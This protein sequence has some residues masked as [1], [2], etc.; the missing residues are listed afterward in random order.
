ML[1]VKALF[2]YTISYYDL[3][4]AGLRRVVFG[5]VPLGL[6]GAYGSSDGSVCFG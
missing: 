5:A 4:P 2:P 1:L 3:V 6:S